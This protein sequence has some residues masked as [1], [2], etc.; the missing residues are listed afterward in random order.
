VLDLH[1]AL[2]AIALYEDDFTSRLAKINAT[3]CVLESR[4]PSINFR[5][6]SQ[7]NKPAMNTRLALSQ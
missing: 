6:I 2:A 4:A 1:V 5:R 3:T 7:Q